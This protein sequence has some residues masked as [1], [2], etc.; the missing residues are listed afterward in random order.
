[1]ARNIGATLSLKDGNFFANIK[2]ATSAVGGLKSALGGGTNALKTHGK[3]ADSVGGRLKSLAGKVVGV[4]AAYASFSTIKN[5]VSDTITLANEQNSAETRLQTTL[6]NV[7]GVT[8]TQIS[9]LKD[10]ASTLQKVTTIGDEVTIHGMSQLGTFQL[11][12]DTIKTLTPALQDLAVS[13][14]GVNVSSEQMQTTAN[15]VGK[16]M[17]GSVSALS[18]YGVVMNDTQK[19]ILQTG[20]ESERAATLVD[21]LKQNFGGLSEAMAKT[22]AGRIQQLKNAW[23]D[24]KEVIGAELYPVLTK[25]LTFATDKIPTVQN[26]LQGVINGA[27][28]L[29]NAIAPALSNLGGALKDLGGAVA[30]AFSGMSTDGIKDVLSSLV[31]AAGDIVRNITPII[32]SIKDVFGSLVSAAGDIVRNITPIIQSIINTF[33]NIAPKLAPIISGIARTI[34]S[35]AARIAPVVNKIVDVIG[36]VLSAIVGFI[37]DHWGTIQSILDFIISGIVFFSN[38]VVDIFS[39][40]VNVI[41]K[42]FSVIGSV[43]AAIWN[44]IKPVVT[45]LTTF[46]SGAFSTA[47]TTIQTVWSAATGFFSAI[48]DTIK[49]VFSVVKD[50]LTGNWSG[51]WEGIKGIVNTWSEYFSGVW[52]GIK[53]VFSAVVEWFGSTFSAAW[54]AVKGVFSAVGSFFTGVWN[55]IKQIFTTIGLAVADAVSG[56][57]KTVVNSVIG[58]AENLINGFIKSVNWAI[59]II[60]NIPGVT[61]PLIQEINLPKLAQGGIATRSTVAEI[62]ERGTEAVLPLKPFWDRLDRALKD[63]GNTESSG[64]RNNVTVNLNVTIPPGESNPE[65]MADQ[66][67][68]VLVPKLKMQLANL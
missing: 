60:N 61:I 41:G 7:A 37:S 25:A 34:S 31:S 12:A 53:G 6:S 55:T 24:M 35:F 45:A 27:K 64:G 19:K 4:V 47:W 15:L 8:Q 32:Q 67:I 49:G 48:W 33:K 10:Y 59:G 23:G 5:F 68:N 21:V 22:P 1:M 46:L 39:G 42:V 38:T 26:A 66:I 40:I 13:Q 62:G 44:K 18:R 14:Y 43:I 63:R 57:F 51:A 30:N 11:Q 36:G 20:T 3:V 9:A 54:E 28:E 65:S 16:V 52:E 17:T 58:F 29:Y 50:V 56:A 2:S